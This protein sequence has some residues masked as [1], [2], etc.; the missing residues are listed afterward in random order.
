MFLALWCVAI[1]E[2]SKSLKVFGKNVWVCARG[3]KAHMNRV[4]V[5]LLIEC[6]C[7]RVKTSEISL[8]RSHKKI[9]T[10]KNGKRTFTTT[11]VVVFFM[12]GL[13]VVIIMKWIFGRCWNVRYNRQCI[14]II[15]DC[16]PSISMWRL[17]TD[18]LLCKEFLH[19]CALLCIT[20][21]V[22]VWE[23]VY[24]AIESLKK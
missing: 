14:F 11:M 21:F 2:E 23:S 9:S 12:C 7:K 15:M 8:W 18:K 22:A 13:V 1:S 4:Y 19:G 6:V 16:L 3:V 24:V 20:V 17:L 5:W 10:Q